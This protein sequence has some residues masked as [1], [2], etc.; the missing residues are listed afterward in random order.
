MFYGCQKQGLLLRTG[1]MRAPGAALWVPSV[2]TLFVYL[3]TQLALNLE[4]GQST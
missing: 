3:V 2:A 4:A 1:G